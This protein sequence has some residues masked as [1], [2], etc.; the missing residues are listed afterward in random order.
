VPGTGGPDGQEKAA[1]ERPGLFHLGPFYV[2]PTIHLKNVGIDTN[3]LYTP[4]DRQTDLYGSGGP[5]LQILLPLGQTGR[6]YTEGTLD[7]MY[8]VRTESQR[9]LSGDVTTGIDLKGVHTQISGKQ[10]WGRTYGRPSYEVDQRI[11]TDIESSHLDLRRRLFGPLYLRMEGARSRSDILTEVDYL[12]VSLRQT[13]SETRYIVRAGL[14]YTLTVKTSF[15]VEGDQQWDRFLYEPTRDADS[16]RAMAG[17]RTDSTALLAGRVLVGQRWF[18]PKVAP[19]VER[20]LTAVDA[21]VVW[22]ITKRTRIA[23]GYVRDL[24]YTAFPTNGPTPTVWTQTYEA[25][26]E[27]DISSRV[28]FRLFGRLNRFVTDGEITVEV[29]DQGV[30][31]A[32]R[33]DR[34]RM[35][36]VD[37]GYRFRSKLRVGV[38]A[39]YT[40]RNSTISYFGID[41]FIFGFNVNYSP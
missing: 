26:I 8:F 28:D 20:R 41:G 19:D 31:V 3:V 6:L 36:G 2:T 15:V 10:I 33:D 27:K 32:V 23:G 13:L 5:G 25:R 35:G 7:Y 37:L 40:D 34:T 14:E 1:E 11:E 4:T 38:S 16:N 12:G 9:R 29:P 21:D 30:V 18:R 17:F 22:N 39:T 24:A